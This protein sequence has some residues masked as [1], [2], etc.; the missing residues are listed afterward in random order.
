[1]EPFHKDE[2]GHTYSSN[3]ARNWEALHYTYPELVNTTKDELKE[4]V[5]KK[6]GGTVNRKLRTPELPGINHEEF[7]DY[8]IN[9]QYDR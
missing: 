1:M 9:I 6:Y 8:I 3:D 2:Q 4:L 7:N 5:K